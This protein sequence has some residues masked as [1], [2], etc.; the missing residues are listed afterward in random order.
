MNALD[1]IKTGISLSSTVRK[2]KSLTKK[3]K[4]DPN[5]FSLQ[6]RSDYLLKKTKG[7]F[8]ALNVE[9]KVK[10]YENLGT[11][12]PAILYGNHQDNIDAL[13]VLYA[14][15]KQSED[16]NIMNKI[17]TFIAKHTLLYSK[18]TRYMLQ[19]IDTFFLDRESIRRSLETYNDFGKFVKEN[20]T[21]GIVFPEGTRNTNGTV[22]EF[23]AGS[24]KIAKKELLP[25]I[26]FTINNS[27]QGLNKNRKGKLV[28]EIIFHK[29]INSSSL[30]T[31]NT[32]SIAE[33]VRNIIMSEFKAPE[34]EFKKDK[35]ER[36][37]ETSKAAV[38]FKKAEQKQMEKEAKKE[39]KARQEEDK[40]IKEEKRES[41]KYE[42]FLEKEKA[43]EEKKKEKTNGKE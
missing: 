39:R 34:L 11:S 19:S 9:V 38:K 4:Q 32:H 31:S 23:K 29:K 33:R 2:T 30:L 27:V 18:K 42:K 41:E 10:G 8:K 7:F 17:P 37:I 24:F 1:K 40:V 21:Y 6:Y 28:I 22:G 12:G 3:A 15:K 16:K 35:E 20:K 43:K 5:K 36:E 25:I 13:V 14:L 26:P